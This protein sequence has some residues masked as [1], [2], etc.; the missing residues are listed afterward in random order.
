MVRDGICPFRG[1]QRDG[2]GDI[3]DEQRDGEG[4]I[5]GD[6]N[7][8]SVKKTNIEKTDSFQNPNAK[9]TSFIL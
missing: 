1:D 2:L 5:D 9:A 4:K 3:R 7:D 6:R 8:W